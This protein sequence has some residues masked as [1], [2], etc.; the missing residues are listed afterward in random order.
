MTLKELLEEIDLV[1]RKILLSTPGT[2]VHSDLVVALFILQDM[3]I[4][5]LVVEAA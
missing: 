3:T 1:K 2:E 5:A 4:K